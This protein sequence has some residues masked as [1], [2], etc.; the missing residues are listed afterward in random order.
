MVLMKRRAVLALAAVPRPASS[1][2]VGYHVD[3]R[4]TT[5]VL[6]IRVENQE[7]NPTIPRFRSDTWK[8]DIQQVLKRLAST[9]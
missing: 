9:T 4:F 7:P 2:N 1:E 5:L 6:V 8:G 3:M